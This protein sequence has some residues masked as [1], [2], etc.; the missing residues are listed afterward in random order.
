MSCTCKEEREG[1]C[2]G[3]STR[4]GGWGLS[5]YRV[6]SRSPAG[7]IFLA[8]WGLSRGS[9]RVALRCCIP[10]SRPCLVHPKTK[11][12]FQDSLSHQILRHMHEALNIYENKN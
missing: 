2:A 4:D 1:S 9:A 6:S 12:T 5:C 8:Y 7:V 10:V 3:A 11:K